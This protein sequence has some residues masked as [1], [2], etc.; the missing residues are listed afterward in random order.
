MRVVVETPRGASG[1]GYAFAVCVGHGGHFESVCRPALHRFMRPQDALIAVYDSTSMFE[2]YDEIFRAATDLANCCGI[3][4]IH[5]DV[6][7]RSDPIAEMSVLAEIADVGLAGALGGAAGTSLAWWREKPERRGLL[8]DRRKV[9]D[10]GGR[11]HLVDVVDDVVLFVPRPTFESTRFEQTPYRGYE[12]LGVILS[13]M[14]HRAGAL[15]A[16]GQFDMFH[17]NDC[18]GFNNVVDWRWNELAWQLD[19]FEVDARRRL[20]SMLQSRLSAL[21]PARIALNRAVAM[22]RGNAGS[23]SDGEAQDPAVDSLVER[24]FRDGKAL[25]GRSRPPFTGS[26]R[27]LEVARV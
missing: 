3:L 11:R 19:F 4:A 2:A 14:V 24:W 18:V 7:V 23:P 16:V 26:S 21:V 10:H 1:T 9:H 25:R 17:H 13:S 27:P 12:G 6:E 22:V 15:V 5:D 20:R 8:V